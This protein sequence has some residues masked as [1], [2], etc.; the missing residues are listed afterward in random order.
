M[1]CILDHIQGSPLTRA[2]LTVLWIVNV[3]SELATL[4]LLCCFFDSVRVQKPYL[5][6]F[7]CVFH[8]VRGIIPT[9][10]MKIKSNSIL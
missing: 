1:W 6:F 8:P 7:F 4:L 5:V 2:G 9:K 10:R 3:A